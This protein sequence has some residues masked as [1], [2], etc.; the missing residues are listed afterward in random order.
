MKV[1]LATT[2]LCSNTVNWWR[3]LHGHKVPV[4]AASAL[5]QTVRLDHLGD[6]CMLQCIQSCCCPLPAAGVA[7]KEVGLATHFI[8]SHLVPELPARLQALGPQLQDL[9]Q[10]GA[11]GWP[12]MCGPGRCCWS[13]NACCGCCVAGAEHASTAGAVCCALCSAALFIQNACAA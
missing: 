5:L 12:C 2:V 11:L 1:R 8:S 9:S 7:L 6:G 4:H 13:C 10:V 3:W